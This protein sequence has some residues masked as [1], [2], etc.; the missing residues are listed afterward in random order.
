[1]DDTAIVS[2]N[3]E[4]FQSGGGK[5]FSWGAAIAGAITAAAIAFILIALGTGVGLALTSPYSGPSVGTMTIGGAVWLVLVQSIAFAAGGFL[6]GRLRARGEAIASAEARFRD[7][8]NGFLVWAIGALATALAIAVIGT[9]SISGGVRAIAGVTQGTSEDQLGYFVDALVRAPV[10]RQTNLTDQD[11]AQVLRILATAIRDGGL[12][13]DDKNYLSSLVA[14]R[15]GLNQD[16][17]QSRVTNIFNRAQESL[18]QVAD[19]ARSAAAYV[20]FWTFM[21][22]LF[23]AVAATLGGILGGELRDEY[24]SVDSA[25]MIPS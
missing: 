25:Q 2:E 4:I 20:A 21:S 3:V 23:G 22:L 16:E 1:M 19:S 8:A 7:G 15:T 13:N 18:K 9:I 12:A 5:T 6:A 24:S 11:R 14:A 17:A 10:S